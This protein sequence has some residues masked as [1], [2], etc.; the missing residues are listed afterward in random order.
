MTSESK[1]EGLNVRLRFILSQDFRDKELMKSLTTYFDCGGCEVAKD[2]M[3]YYKV[4]NFADNYGKILPFFSTH[5]LAGVKV[6][7]FED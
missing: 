2:G 5:Q 7:D 6:K 4:T 3:V 1:T